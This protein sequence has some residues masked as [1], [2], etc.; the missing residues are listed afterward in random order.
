MKK[1]SI[2]TV[3][4]NSTEVTKELLQ[5]LRKQDYGNIEIIVV[6]NGSR[7]DPSLEI[8]REFPEVM[9]VRSNENLGFAGGNNLGIAYATGDLLLFLNNDTEVPNNSLLKMAEAA[10]IPGVAMVSPV[11]CYHALPDKIQYA[12]YTPINIFTGRNKSIGHA[13]QYAPVKGI[14]QTAYPHGAALMLTRETMK[15]IGTMPNNYF[16]YYEELEWG[17]KAHNS[18]FLTVVQKEALIYHKESM[19][20]GKAS[21]LKTYFQTRNRILFMRRNNHLLTFLL[22]SFFFGLFA[23]PKNLFSYILKGQWNHLKHFLAG[24]WWNLTNGSNSMNIGYK[25]DYLRSL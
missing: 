21:P 14:V 17:A 4:F 10:S 5:S 15:K 8:K 3:N 25:Y 16:L 22:F 13:K 24:V 6:D 1:I 7:R 20:T 19:S 2:I 11:I 23:L 18:G 12:G 9:M